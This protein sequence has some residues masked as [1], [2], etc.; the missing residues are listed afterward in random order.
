MKGRASGKTG[1]QQAAREYERRQAE[2]DSA[3]EVVLGA[4]LEAE[5]SATVRLVALRQARDEALERLEE[6]QNIDTPAVVLDA[7]ADW[8]SMSREARRG[9]IKAVLAHALVAPGR[10]DDRITYEA[11]G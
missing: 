1:A 5:A 2:L 7:A 8:D 9:M 10:G 6:L 11:R 4:G 3:I